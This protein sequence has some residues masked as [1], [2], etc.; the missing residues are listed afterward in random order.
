MKFVEEVV[1]DDFLP[2]FRSMLAEALRERG[3]TQHEVAEA[4]GVSQSAV[5]K[6]VHGE[7]ARRTEVEEHTRVRAL[8]QEIADGLASGEMTRAGALVEAEVLIRELEDDGLVAR[9]HEAE[10]PEFAEYAG[11]IR[12]PEGTVRTAGRASRCCRRCVVG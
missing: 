10:M 3:F 8:V 12:D 5:S 2:T 9:L 1:V 4:L 7:V 11:R 6:Y